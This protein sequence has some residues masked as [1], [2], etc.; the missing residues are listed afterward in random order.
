MPKWS[1]QLKVELETTNTQ[2]VLSVQ[3]LVD[4]GTTNLPHIPILE[5]NN[6]PEVAE[7]PSFT[8]FMEEEPDPDASHAPPPHSRFP[9]KFDHV[10]AFLEGDH[11][12]AAAVCPLPMAKHIQASQTTLQRLAEAFVAN[13]GPWSFWDAVPNHLHDFE[14]IFTKASFDSLS[15]HKQ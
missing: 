15:D 13:A 10:K 9:S 12:Y 2:E 7:F 3:A 14:D 1:L 8:P 4:S 11:I 6:N 5:D